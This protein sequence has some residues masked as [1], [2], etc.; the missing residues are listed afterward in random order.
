MQTPAD[1]NRPSWPSA[2]LIIASL[3][4]LAFWPLVR[5][6][7]QI[8]YSDHS[9]ML[10]MH[11]PMKYFLVQS[12]QQT[13]ELPLWCPSSFAGLPFVH[14]VQL[15]A[16]YPL[17]LPLYLIRP[18]YVGAAVSWLV[19]LHVIIAGCGMFCYARRTS[20]GWHGALAAGGAWMFGGKWMMHMIDGGHCIMA[21]LAWLPWILLCLDHAN[22]ATVTFANRI[23]WA[24]ASGLVFGMMVLGTHPQITFYCGLAIGLSILLSANMGRT[25]KDRWRKLPLVVGCGIWCA[26]V[27]VGLG[28]IQLL[29]AMEAAPETS[30][31]GGVSAADILPGGLRVLA[32]F[33]GPAIATVDP[34]G[35]WKTGAVSR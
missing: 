14:D 17:H 11:V 28:A 19:V 29:P 6:P 10:A 31:A 5:S 27:A 25:S 26:V 16:F 34:S 24:T 8:L 2:A 33:V 21:P 9:D 22:A 1:S 23:R 20:L 18:G 15:A 35:G 32:N 7:T 12:F 30:R 3:A 4:L 13:G